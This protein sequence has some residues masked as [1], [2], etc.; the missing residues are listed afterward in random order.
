MPDV[1][2]S[3]SRRD[4][5]FV[6][7]LVESLERHGR[8]VWIDVDG[9]G[10]GE[11]FPAAIRS[12]IEQS[13]AFLFVIT[14]ASVESRYCESEIEHA[15]ELNKRVVPLLREVVSDERLPEAIRIRHWIQYTQDVDVEAASE[16]LVAALD[17]DIER[18]R[19]H[20]R[21]LVK[22]LE[23]STDRSD[24][25]ILLRGS[26]LAAAEVWLAGAGE[27]AE[28]AP[29]TLQRE[30]IYA[31][32]SAATRRQRTGVVASLLGIVVALALAGFA[33]ISRNQAQAQALTSDAE[34]VSTLALSEPS[35]DRSFLLAVAGLRLQDRPE[36]RGNLLAVLQKTPALVHLT[37]VS[38]N[39]LP[40]LVVS[41]DERLLAS[42]D[43]AGVIRFINL[44]TWKT[45][46]ATA[47]VDGAVSM[48]AMRFSPDGRTL[49]IGTQRGARRSDLYLLDVPSRTRGGSG[50]GLPSRPSQDRCDSPAWRSHP[51][52]RG[53]RSPWR[54]RRRNHPCR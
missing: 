42:G 1:F 9:I 46:G 18:A 10:G 21:W 22:A 8:S 31:G 52:E 29:T 39:D 35:P 24:R 7:E 34:R 6:E 40:A 33:F 17:A 49:A 27:Q 38:G 12:A 45:D 50:P 15:L 26:E 14:P 48:D 32:R 37:H 54:Q 47:R 44:R 41:P 43:S 20:T 2:V 4:A 30:Y 28:P 19:A 51:T 13:D 5:A 25:S 3:Y 36:T 23:W 16:R 53:S 11:V